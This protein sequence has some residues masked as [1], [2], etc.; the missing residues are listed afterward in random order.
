MN[1]Y[2]ELVERI[3]NAQERVIGPVAI[4]QAK[5]V[6]GL[7]ID[8]SKREVNIQGDSSEVLEALVKQYEHLFGQASVEVCKDAV[9][10][11]IDGFPKGQLPPV[12]A[13]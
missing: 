4:E 6:N 5:R 3:I 9:K 11:M 12:L 10:G 13:S 1:A 2:S 7:T 8:W